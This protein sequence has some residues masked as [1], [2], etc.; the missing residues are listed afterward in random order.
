MVIYNI[1]NMGDVFNMDGIK[2]KLKILIIVTALLPLFALAAAAAAED[3]ADGEFYVAVDYYAEKIRILHPNSV[4]PRYGVSDYMEIY[5]N[6]RALGGS[7]ASIGKSDLAESISASRGGEYMY[8]LKAVSDELLDSY[9]KAGRNQKKI[10]A[11]HKE[12]WYPIYGGGVDISK[13]IPPKTAKNMKK[14]YYI[15]VRRSDDVFDTEDGYKSRV[16]VP[17]KPRY[18]ERE[19]RKFIEY[20][21]E[22][23][24]IALSANYPDGDFLNIVYRYEYFDSMSGVLTKYAASPGVNIDVPGK[25]FYFGGYVYIA[26]MPHLKDG[27]FGPEV[28]FARSKEIKFKIPKVSAG[29]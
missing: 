13:I 11:L 17:I 21:A 3:A 14:Q 20:N 7:H 12:K 1:K 27:Y 24:K 4:L 28:V 22:N 16:T 25:L 18:S 6:E 8:A 29:K 10:A 2:S 26:S 9:V 5:D 23:E 19:L 15:A